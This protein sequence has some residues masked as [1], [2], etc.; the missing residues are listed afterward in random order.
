MDFGLTVGGIG[1][2]IL[3]TGKRDASSLPDT[4]DNSVDMETGP[5]E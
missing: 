3:S 5:G 2:A 4:Q 1:A